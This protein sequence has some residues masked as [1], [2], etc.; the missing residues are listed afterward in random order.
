MDGHRPFAARLMLSSSARVL[1]II[2]KLQ[3]TRNS[4]IFPQK[5]TNL[6]LSKGFMNCVLPVALGRSFGSCGGGYWQHVGMP[7]S[8]VF[9]W[10]KGRTDRWM[11]PRLKGVNDFSV[12]GLS[13]NPDGERDLGINSLHLSSSGSKDIIDIAIDGN[14]DL[15][16]GQPNAAFCGVI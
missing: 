4:M 3:C 6:S 10:S 9:F 8:S 14:G 1:K 5:G 15:F 11:L 16:A 13:G 12:A 2:K 7:G